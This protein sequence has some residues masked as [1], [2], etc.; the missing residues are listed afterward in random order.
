MEEGLYSHPGKLLSTHLINTHYIALEKFERIKSCIN[1]VLEPINDTLLEDN[2]IKTEDVELALKIACLLHDLGK[3]TKFFQDYLQQKKIPD[4]EYTNHSLFSAYFAYFI[5]QELIDKDLLNF[6]TFFIIKRHHSNLSDPLNETPS[7]IKEK[8]KI[9]EKQLNS[10]QDSKN[11]LIQKFEILCEKLEKYLGFKITLEKLTSYLKKD[12]DKEFLRIRKIIRNMICKNENSKL[13]NLYFLINLMFS[14]LIE[15]DKIEAIIGKSQIVPNIEDLIPNFDDLI[16]NHIENLQYQNP[17]D[18]LR[19][20]AYKKTIENLHKFLSENSSLENSRIFCVNLPTGIGKTFINF[21]IALKLYKKLINKKPKIIYCLPF[22]SIIEQTYNSISDIIDKKLIMK[23]HSLTEIKYEDSEEWYFNNLTHDQIRFLLEDWDA[24]IVITTFVQLFHT[25][26]SNSNSFIKRLNKLSNSIIILDEIQAIEPKK[27]ELINQ[28]LTFLSKELNSYIIISTATYPYIFEEEKVRY[29]SP[30][31]EIYT[32]KLDRFQ[33]EINLKEKTIKQLYE[34][35]ISEL[36]NNDKKYLFIFNTINSA[37]EFYKMLE[38]IEEK[39]FLATSII[40]KHRLQRILDIKQ[41]KYRIVVSTQLVEA[42]VDIDFDVVIRDLA[43]LDSLNQSAG[44]CNRNSRKKGL[45]KIYN[46]VNDKCHKFS[47]FIYD[48][49]LISKT[50][51]LLLMKTE[52]LKTSTIN[53]YQFFDILENYYC[54]LKEIVSQN[55]SN[56]TLSALYKLKYDSSDEESIKSFKLIEN[57][58][59]E[60][61]VFIQ[62]DDEAEKI[63]QKYFSLSEIKDPFKRKEEFDKIKST[64]FEHTISI[65]LNINNLPP[66]LPGHL[67]RFVSKDDLPNYYDLETGYKT[68]TE[69]IIIL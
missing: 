58:Y 46:L 10:I 40:P 52:K 15:S 65:P 12:I 63:L 5:S 62:V 35:I 31:V 48:K 20:D 29:L 34:E 23:Y 1:D 69:G 56:S 2:K 55:K 36:K 6:I 37:K 9:I 54:Q 50:Q 59:P 45:F 57:D 68:N 22:L 19:K 3:S 21:S 30:S 42:G 26:I 60:I 61:L 17:I 18:E 13:L 33:V 43:P 51:E 28:T 47:S 67:I 64:F 14:I 16:D 38:D 53:E 8:L 41:N 39:T 49:T 7:K 66:L 44:R 4:K 25:L 11:S 27:R 24:P 32:K